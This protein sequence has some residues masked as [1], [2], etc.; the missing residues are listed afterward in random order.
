MLWPE[1]MARF[2]SPCQIVS[3]FLTA[4]LVAVLLIFLINA[5]VKHREEKES[6]SDTDDGVTVTAS[7]REVAKKVLAVFGWD[8]PEDELEILYYYNI[9][10]P[11]S[12]DGDEIQN[13]RRRSI[14]DDVDLLTGK[15][16]ETTLEEDSQRLSESLLTSA[17]NGHKVRNIK[18]KIQ[19]I[20]ENSQLGRGRRGL[21]VDDREY[22]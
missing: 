7:L 10:K 11:S 1:E 19:Q 8:K 18:Q 15:D 4:T 17:A 14:D 6:V 21:R 13:R 16:E 2:E 20:G 22:F 3:L 5:E 9:R 12:S